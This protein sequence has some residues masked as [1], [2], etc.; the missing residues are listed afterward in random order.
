MRSFFFRETFIAS[1]WQELI[2]YHLPSYQ[3]FLHEYG[4]LSISIPNNF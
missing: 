3:D 4:F 2:T 1:P